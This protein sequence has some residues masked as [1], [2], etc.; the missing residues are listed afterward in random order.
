M[1]VKPET[2]VYGCNPVQNRARQ[3]L[4]QPYFAVTIA[5]SIPGALALI[6]GKRFDLILLDESIAETDCLTILEAV[7]ELLPI[8]TKVLSLCREPGRFR[9]TAPHEELGAVSPADILQK[10]AA[11][12][13]IRLLDDAAPPQ[14]SRTNARP[15]APDE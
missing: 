10:A 5:T 13:G 4:L 1:T 3:L 6:S 12:T 15:I 2:L 8:Q 14:A 7:H 11:M 9:L